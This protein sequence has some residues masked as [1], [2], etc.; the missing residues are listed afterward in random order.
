MATPSI[1]W[2]K[3]SEDVLPGSREKYREILAFRPIFGKI[4]SKSQMI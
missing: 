1:D 2:P 4:V 3:V